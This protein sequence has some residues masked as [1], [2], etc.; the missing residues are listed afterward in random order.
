MAVITPA[1]WLVATTAEGGL[2]EAA[3][4][5]AALEQSPTANP[6]TLNNVTLVF[7]GD[8]STVTV[9]ATIPVNATVNSTGGIVL[10][11]DPYLS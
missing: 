8:T 11:A 7:N 10:A 3:Q 5:V 6:D 1:T 2:I 9:T 4:K